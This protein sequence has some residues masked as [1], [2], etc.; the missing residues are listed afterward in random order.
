MALL[1]EDDRIAC[2]ISEDIELAVDAME[3]ARLPAT[4]AAH[5]YGRG[6]E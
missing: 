1:I 2:G 6:N 3:I 4:A 5:P